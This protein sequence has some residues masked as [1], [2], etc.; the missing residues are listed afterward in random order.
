[1]VAIVLDPA[2]MAV[3]SLIAFIWSYGN[4]LDIGLFCLFA[5]GRHW[6]AL[7]GLVYLYINPTIVIDFAK[8]A[9]LWFTVFQL[10]RYLAGLATPSAWCDEF[11]AKPM[12]FPCKTTHTRLFPKKHSFS[13]SY[14]YMGVP[15]GWRGSSGGLLSADEPKDEKPWYMKW[16]SFRPGSWFSVDGD[17][18]LARGHVE[19]GLRGKLDVYIQSEVCLTLE[20]W[21][22]DCADCIRVKN[23]KTILMPTS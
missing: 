23:P 8:A 18:Y 11:P 20:C 17:H 10:A 22:L 9:V 12:L 4:P 3:I 7:K 16:L 14:L 6:D 21:L 1:M 5:L 19:G 2:R 13:Y 15:V